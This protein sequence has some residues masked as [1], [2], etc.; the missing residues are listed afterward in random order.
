MT[1][2][3]LSEQL[4][5]DGDVLALIRQAASVSVSMFSSS[6]SRCSHM[7]PLSHGCSESRRRVEGGEILR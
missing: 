7:G 6:H 5:D 3:A 4:P 1:S 2:C